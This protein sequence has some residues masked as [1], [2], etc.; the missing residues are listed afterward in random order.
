MRVGIGQRSRHSLGGFSKMGPKLSVFKDQVGPNSGYVS[1]AE[2]WKPSG[3]SGKPLYCRAY[4]SSTGNR[5][6]PGR[7]RRPAP[8]ALVM[9]ARPVGLPAEPGKPF[10]EPDAQAVERHGEQGIAADGEDHIHDLRLA[11]AAAERRPA[12]LAEAGILPKLVGG[13]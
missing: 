11:E 4:F 3:S 10:I 9:A 13:A 2:F 7:G 8:R 1:H 5:R 6:G 12:R